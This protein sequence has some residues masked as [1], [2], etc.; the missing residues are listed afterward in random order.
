[1]LSASNMVYDDTALTLGSETAES[2]H[3]YFTVPDI[4]ELPSIPENLIRAA[5]CAS[6]SISLGATLQVWPPQVYGS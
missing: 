3:S 6:A 4:R 5:R 1:M 2:T